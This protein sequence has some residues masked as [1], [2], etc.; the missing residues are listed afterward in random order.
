[1]PRRD[2]ESPVGPPP[3]SLLALDFFPTFSPVSTSS[4]SLAPFS[5]LSSFDR[6]S[7]LSHT[8][9]IIHHGENRQDRIVSPTSRMHPGTT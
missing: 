9:D 7:L 6:H 8:V 2:D 5:F 1:M 4:S 3:L